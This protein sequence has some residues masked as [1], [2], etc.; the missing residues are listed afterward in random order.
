MSAPY[1]SLAFLILLI[2]LTSGCTFASKESIPEKGKCIPP[3]TT[4]S[5][6]RDGYKPDPLPGE[7][8]PLEPWQE[9][10]TV[11]EP[12]LADELSFSFLDPQFARTVN[13]SV[14]IWVINDW[15]KKKDPDSN[16][17]IY[18]Y[19]PDKGTWSEVPAMMEKGLVEIFKLYL[20]TDGTIWAK[21]SNNIGSAGWFVSREY[22]ETPYVFGKYNETENRF[23][24]LDFPQE[25]PLGNG[26]YN[27]DKFWLF[28]EGGAIYSLDFKTLKVKRHIDPRNA[29]WD[30]DYYI[31]PE[32]Y[33]HQDD[34]LAFM[35][36][37]SFYFLDETPYNY[38]VPQII[39]MYHFNPEI[40]KL[41]GL[42]AINLENGPPFFDI[43]TDRAGNLWVSDQGWMN[44]E[45]KWHEIV[46]SPVFITTRME[47]TP[48]IWEHPRILLQ[49]SNGV[50]WYSATNGLVSLDPQKGEWCWFTTYRS[51]IVEDAEQNLWMIADG[52]L[53][54]NPLAD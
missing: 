19:R 36:D 17:S 46:R 13:G 30:E 15:G 14:E 22:N 10:S 21:A 34:S 28:E 4:F 7:I 47:A 1:K 49:S 45:G 39:D 11:P 51:D 41:E 6:P 9:V 40:N 32:N 53:Y 43:F 3:I 48:I 8:S 23:E 54:K 44:Q 35:E 25:I 12:L 38:Y 50:L 33:I 31:T 37:G 52:K 5:F 24:R 29:I 42:K 2:W 18:V 26:S 16:H 27:R 20:G